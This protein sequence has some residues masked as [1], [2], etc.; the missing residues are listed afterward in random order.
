LYRSH[1]A[2][3]IVATVS[4]SKKASLC[5]KWRPSQKI[6]I[7]YSAE[8][9]PDQK[10]TPIS[11][12]LHQWL[13]ERLRRWGGECKSGTARP[14]AVSQS[15]LDC[16]NGSTSGYVNMDGGIFMVSS[17]HKELQARNNCWEYN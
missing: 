7:G 6:T 3:T 17:L 1:C 14:S 9:N 5:S 2:W 12:M 13:R 11:K 10:D 16:D 4:P 15:L 8:E